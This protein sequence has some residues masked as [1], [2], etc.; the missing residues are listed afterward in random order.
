[1]LFQHPLITSWIMAM[2]PNGS[3]RER[4]G[5]QS[6][7]NTSPDRYHRRWALCQKH[8]RLLSVTFSV[9]T[10]CSLR[11]RRRRHQSRSYRPQ[12]ADMFECIGNTRIRN[13]V[14]FVQKGWSAGNTHRH[15]LKKCWIGAMTG[16]FSC[17]FFPYLDMLVI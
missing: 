5:F 7:G 14:L 8:R 1:M 11:K 12:P 15:Y 9:C 10:V 3:R 2:F 16:Y 4:R 13:P 6:R 17:S